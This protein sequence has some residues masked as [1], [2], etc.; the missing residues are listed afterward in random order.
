M[1]V[2]LVVFGI[3]QFSIITAII[4]VFVFVMAVNEYRMVR[5]DGLLD[6]YTVADVLRPQFTPLYADE[7]LSALSTVC[8]T[9]Q[10]ATSLSSTA[11]KISAA[12]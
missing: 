6:D 5:F 10:N 4:G 12:P 7:P 8:S 2:G 9:G 11:G 3:W 1:A